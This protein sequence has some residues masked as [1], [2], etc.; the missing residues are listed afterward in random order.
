VLARQDP[1]ANAVKRLTILNL[2]LSILGQLRVFFV[3]SEA[4]LATYENQRTTPLSLF[5]WK[6]HGTYVTNTGKRLVRQRSCRKMVY[7][8]KMPCLNPRKERAGHEKTTTKARNDEGTKKENFV[9][10]LFRILWR[11]SC[12]QAWLCLMFSARK[13]IKVISN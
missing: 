6:T 10:S 7:V 3:V 12:E 1:C 11:S 13:K 2:Q 4:G 8:F 5:L 9:F